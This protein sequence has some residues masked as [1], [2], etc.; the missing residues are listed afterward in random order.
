MRI[1]GEGFEIEVNNAGIDA[2]LELK[3][4]RCRRWTEDLG[5]Y[6]VVTVGLD[7]I[8]RLADIHEHQ[9]PGVV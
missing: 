2:S 3:C 5:C 9:C 6:A 4:T 7:E 8:I 1:T